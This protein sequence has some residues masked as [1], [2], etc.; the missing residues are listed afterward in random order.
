MT[1]SSS[2]EDLTLMIR[3]NPPCTRPDGCLSTKKED[4]QKKKVGDVVL[5]E[6]K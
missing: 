4:K 6:H 3:A 2:T 1:H 5:C